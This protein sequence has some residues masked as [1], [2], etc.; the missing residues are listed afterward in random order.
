[1][2][3]VGGMAGEGDENPLRVKGGWM[4]SRKGSNFCLIVLLTLLLF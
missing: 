1:M 4:G 2:V 3:E